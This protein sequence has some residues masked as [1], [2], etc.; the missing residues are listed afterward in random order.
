MTVRFVAF[1]FR[2]GGDLWARSLSEVRSLTLQAGR[3]YRASLD[4]A[5]F[6]LGHGR[7]MVSVGVFSGGSGFEPAQRLDYLSQCLCLRVLESNDSDPPVLHWNGRWALGGATD[8]VEARVS[9]V[10]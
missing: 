10:Q 9:G 7:F 4:L 8:D 6:P 3:S 2:L 1:F 5:P